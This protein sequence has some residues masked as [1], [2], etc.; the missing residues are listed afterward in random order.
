[1]LAGPTALETHRLVSEFDRVLTHLNESTAHRH[2]F[3]QSIDSTF[4]GLHGL[5]VAAS[6]VTRQLLNRAIV[7][8]LGDDLWS[9]SSRGKRFHPI[10]RERSLS[11]SIVLPQRSQLPPKHQAVAAT[12]P[13]PLL[14]FG[15]FGMERH[16]GRGMLTGAM[17]AYQQRF[18]GRIRVGD[19]RHFLKKSAVSTSLATSM[20]YEHARNSTFCL[21]PA[22][23]APSFTQRFYQ[24][25]FAGCIPVFVDLYLRYPLDERRAYP[26]PSQICWPKFV[27][28][29][30]RSRAAVLE[31]VGLDGV[32]AVPLNHS[33]QHRAGDAF[34]QVLLDEFERLAPRLARLERATAQLAAAQQ[35]MASIANL[36]KFDAHSAVDGRLADPDASSAALRE[37]AVRLHVVSEPRDPCEGQVGWGSRVRTPPTRT[38]VRKQLLQD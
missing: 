3:L 10:R 9:S 17:L 8:H 30:P 4:V 27:V 31:A 34:R 26:Y 2:V 5:R 21:C 38:S 1:M 33:E 35:Y 18:P 6:S 15:A 32:P 22:G 11:N 19:M 36:L 7:M 29:V 37:L 13:R 16:P 12:S 25:I 23:D 20:A 28:E 14:V 24:S